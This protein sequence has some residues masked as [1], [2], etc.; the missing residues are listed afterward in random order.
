M[1]FTVTAS[2]GIAQAAPEND[3]HTA[4]KL[5]D[6]ALYRAK[7]AGRDNVVFWPFEAASQPCWTNMPV[8]MGLA[9]T[10]PFCSVVWGWGGKSFPPRGFF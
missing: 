3:L 10:E 7:D 2:F 1:R 9:K 8:H 5:A 6:E 4:I